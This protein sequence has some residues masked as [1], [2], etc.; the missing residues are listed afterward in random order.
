MKEKLTFEQTKEKALRLLE[1]R[2]H[3]EAELRE[4]L[5]RA[6]GT[7]ID[8]V[9][10]FC[11]EYNFLND[12]E[13]A[14]KLARDLVNLK[15]YGK[16]RV[17]LELKLKGIESEFIDEAIEEL[18]EVDIREKLFPLVEKRLGGNVDKKNTD[19]VIRYFAYRGY[20]IDDIKSCI[21][22]VKRRLEYGI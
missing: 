19:K 13:Y 12:R 17:Y 16:R 6:G 11:Y 2:S 7:D 14:K 20:E 3:S 1:F 8:N 21:E 18:S 9:I 5:F 4:K 15:A 22:E 10:A